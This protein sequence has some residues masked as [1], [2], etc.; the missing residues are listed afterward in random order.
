MLSMHLKWFQFPPHESSWE[1]QENV[2]HATHLLDRF[3]SAV[4]LT[5]ETL[6]GRVNAPQAFIGEL[7]AFC[8]L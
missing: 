2:D 7:L 8:L 6:K 3:W 4:K 5:P 1:P